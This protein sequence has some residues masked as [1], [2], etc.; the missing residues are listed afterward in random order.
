MESE[1]SS[2]EINHKRLRELE[3]STKDF[4][5]YFYVQVEDLIHSIDLKPGIR[6]YISDLAIKY[7]K[8]HTNNSPE[9]FLTELF[10]KFGYLGK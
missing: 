3:S 2:N 10:D 1:L 9:E 6:S 7:K 4:Q 5:T 8:M